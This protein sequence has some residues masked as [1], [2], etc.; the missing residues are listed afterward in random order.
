MNKSVSKISILALII[1]LALSF[2][3]CTKKYSCTCVYTDPQGDERIITSEKNFLND[4][5]AEEWCIE[6]KSNIDKSEDGSEVKCKL[7]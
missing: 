6:N 1:G 2:S 7:Q 3:F 4:R 5:N